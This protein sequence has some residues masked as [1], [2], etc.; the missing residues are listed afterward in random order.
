MA[1]SSERSAAGPRKASIAEA[2]TSSVIAD[3]I[4]ATTTKALPMPISLSEMLPTIPR[5]DALIARHGA[6]PAFGTGMVERGRSLACRC[7]RSFLP[8]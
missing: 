5:T 1:S 2:N 4:D 8:G 3:A 6:G 7:W